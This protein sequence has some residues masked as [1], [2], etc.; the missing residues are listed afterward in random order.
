MFNKLNADFD[1]ESAA[2]RNLENI[3]QVGC[4]KFQVLCFVRLYF[5]FSFN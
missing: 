4:P 5:Q 1:K 3:I 2:R